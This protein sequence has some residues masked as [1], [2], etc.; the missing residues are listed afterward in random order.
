MKRYALLAALL[1]SCGL[2]VNS[3]E[4]PSIEFERV[5]TGHLFTDL[6]RGYDYDYGVL[7]YLSQQGISCLEIDP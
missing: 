1:S 6:Y 3:N 5:S 2:E 7:C 4:P